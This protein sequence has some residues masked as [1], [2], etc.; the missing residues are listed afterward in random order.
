MSW[1]D[2]ARGVLQEFVDA[3]QWRGQDLGFDPFLFV[4]VDSYHAGRLETQ[5]RID[6]ATHTC[7]MCGVTISVCSRTVGRKRYCGRSCSNRAHNAR[8]GLTP[9]GRRVVQ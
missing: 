5:R 4:R 3:A 8:H 6:G 9:G 7:A 1:T 2:I